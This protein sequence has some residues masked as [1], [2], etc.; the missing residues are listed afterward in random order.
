[1]EITRL[2]RTC[3]LLALAAAQAFGGL[4]ITT[5]MDGNLDGIDD[6]F[7]I[8]RTPG[9]MSANDPAFL[10]M[11]TIAPPTG[12]TWATRPG[13]SWLAP[14]ASAESGFDV[15]K[16]VYHYTVT[17][18]LG[19]NGANYMLYGGWAADGNGLDILVNGISTGWQTLAP[20]PGAAAGSY[21]A[22]TGYQIMPDSCAGGCF[23]AGD[24]TLTFVI[25]NGGLES[26]LAV[27]VNGEAT[28]E[29]G[30]M[31]LMAGG[32]LVFGFWRRR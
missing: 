25:D 13:L 2:I 31:M 11:N 19:A 29:P 15:P 7:A 9:N 3:A 8:T 4:I 17:V 1:M 27:E 21:T 32:L 14:V 16:G 20:T 23:A 5:G 24:N 26:G 6:N 10:V 22:F 12:G 28:P 30:T 18:N